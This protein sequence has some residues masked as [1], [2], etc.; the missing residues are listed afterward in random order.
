LLKIHQD[1]KNIAI[2]VSKVKNIKMFKINFRVSGIL[3]LW[4]FMLVSASAQL[5][6]FNKIDT[7]KGYNSQTIALDDGFLVFNSPQDYNDTIKFR[8]TKFNKNCATVDWIHDYKTDSL[9]GNYDPDA[10]KINDEIF[11]LLKARKEANKP[12]IITLVKIKSDGNLIWAKNYYTNELKISSYNANLLKQT[13]SKF[14]YI[15]SGD[16]KGNTAIISI[17]P[18]SGSISDSRLVKNIR[19]N[20]S[21]FDQDGNLFIFSADSLYA[22]LRVNTSKVDSM[23]WAKKIK[24][25]FFASVNDPLP[26]QSST[27]NRVATVIIDT[28]LRRDTTFNQTGLD[29]AIYKLV[30]FDFDGTIKLESDGFIGPDY[31]VWPVELKYNSVVD[32]NSLYVMTK[33]RVGFYSNDLKKTMDA[34]YYK[35]QKDTF[36]VVDASL[37][38]LD[39]KSI[40]MSGFCYKKAPN[41]EFNILSPYL[42]VSK[43]QPQPDYTIEAEEPVCLK[44]SIDKAKVTMIS[45]KI[46]SVSLKDSLVNFY[47]TDQKFKTLTLDIA[48]FHEAKCGKV[49]MNKTEEVKE[50][51]PGDDYPMSVEWLLWADYKWNTGEETNT[52]VKNKPGIYTVTATL[53]DTVKIS[54]F[55]YKLTDDVDACFSVLIPEA[56][57]PNDQNDSLNNT[58]L[59]FQENPFPYSTFTL[60]VFDRWGEKVFETNDFKEGWDGNFRGNSMPAGVYLYNLH[61]EAIFDEKKYENTLNGQILLLR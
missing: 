16:Q 4:F 2:F 15:V 55:E 27:G 52:V 29:T 41:N 5:S 38:V 54:K 35:F 23:I 51:C 26:I 60:Q 32:K 59:S 61:W 39:D 44:D 19:H 43:T 48:K 46:E 3:F 40:L 11:L 58:F 49:K 36:A 13:N 12:E 33:N 17:D 1:F 53:C 21:A 7:F 14:L 50:F 57:I 25:R 31:K 45:T 8:L 34:K 10:I 28:L 42:F 24:N 47:L 6:V 9:T 56:F 18:A 37:E 22:K 20:S 30:A